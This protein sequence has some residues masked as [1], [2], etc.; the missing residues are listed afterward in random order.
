M[1]VIL[2]FHD[3]I[4][5]KAGP[6]RSWS[7]WQP[8]FL[9]LQGQV[10]YGRC[11]LYIDPHEGSLQTVSIQGNGFPAAFYLRLSVHLIFS[12]CIEQQEMSNSKVSGR[13]LACEEE[14]ISCPSRDNSEACSEQFFRE[15]PVGL[16][17]S[18]AQPSSD[19]EFTL[20]WFW[21]VSFP[22]ALGMLSGITF[23]INLQWKPYLWVFSK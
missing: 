10:P 4:I 6:E 21:P 12:L 8:L 13:N 11:Y 9:D 7:N 16:N 15:C 14:K 1:A 20:D 22:P 3:D 18:E 2:N 5:L 17:P 23:K 19:D